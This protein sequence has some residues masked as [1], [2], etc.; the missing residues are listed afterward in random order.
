MRQ[1]SPSKMFVEVLHCMK[2]A[3]IWSF[4]VRMRE[5]TDLKKLRI[6]T[7]FTQCWF[8]LWRPFCFNLLCS[9]IL[10][11]IFEHIEHSI[12]DLYCLQQIFNWINRFNCLLA[13][14][15]K[16]TLWKSLFSTFFS[17]FALFWFGFTSYLC[18]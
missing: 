1:S 16:T 17:S 3:Q 6:W 13:R 10:R 5:N 9:D 11:I 18:I 8:Y 2:S 12:V 15:V 7:L 14:N 4:F